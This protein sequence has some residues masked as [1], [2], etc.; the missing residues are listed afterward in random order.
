MSVKS[1]QIKKYQVHMYRP[2]PMNWFGVTADITCIIECY[3][4]EEG[5]WDDGNHLCRVYFVAEGSELP[6]SFYQPQ[7]HGGGIF[8]HATELA[9]LIDLLRNEKPVRAYLNSENPER[10]KI[11]TGLEPVGEGENQW[12]FARK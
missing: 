2:F 11:Y 9:P 5:S 7:A 4:D 1:F 12:V 3:E 10:N 8:L 6:V